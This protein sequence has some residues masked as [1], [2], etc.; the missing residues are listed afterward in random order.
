MVKAVPS[1]PHAFDIFPQKYVC[2]G[3]SDMKQG[4]LYRRLD[5]IGHLVHGIGANQQKVGTTGFNAAC[6]ICEYV[7]GPPPNRRCAVI[8]Q[9]DQNRHC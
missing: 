7:T 2:R 4:D 1:N 8:F 5:L 3:V 6:R 9:W